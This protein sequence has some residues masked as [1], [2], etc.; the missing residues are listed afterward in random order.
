MKRIPKV[1]TLLIP[2]SLCVLLCSSSAFAQETVSEDNTVSTENNTSQYV[3]NYIDWQKEK[4]EKDWQKQSALYQGLGWGFF[5][6]GALTVTAGSIVLV[7]DHETNEET[8]I[9]HS[10]LTFCIC[11]GIGGLA[12]LTGA[13]LLIAEAVKFG[14]Y[15]RGEVS[16]DFTWY[17]EIYAS[18]EMTGLGIRGRF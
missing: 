16:G 9:S 14:P 6:A 8:G 1:I 5:W 7:T 4:E 17:P 13:S 15:R 10:M 12:V 11:A 18:T 2:L 3:L